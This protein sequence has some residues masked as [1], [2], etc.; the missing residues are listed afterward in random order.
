MMMV[1]ILQG[2]DNQLSQ[3]LSFAEYDAIGFFSL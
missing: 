3:P 2:V 1:S